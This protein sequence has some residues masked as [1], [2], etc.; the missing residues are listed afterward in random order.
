MIEAT[1]APRKATAHPRAMDRLGERNNSLVQYSFGVVLLAYCIVK[2][3][4]ITIVA[5]V[6]EGK[7]SITQCS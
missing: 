6:Y 4:P 2:G 7:A 5:H 1:V 3:S